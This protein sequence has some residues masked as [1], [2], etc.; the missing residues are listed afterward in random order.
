MVEIGNNKMVK[1][2]DQNLTETINFELSIQQILK[3]LHQSNKLKSLLHEMAIEEILI[4][5]AHSNGIEISNDDLQQTADDFRYRTGLNSALDTN[6]W[7][8]KHGLSVLDFEAFLERKLL[9]KKVKDL[10]AH[11]GA[12]DCFSSNPKNYTRVTYRIILVLREDLAQEIV[13]QVREGIGTFNELAF[14]YSQHPSREVGGLIQNQ[15]LKEMP[16]KIAELILCSRKGEII[17]P[18]STKIGFVLVLLE[19]VHP[20][21]LNSQTMVFI[22]EELIE[23]WLIEKIS[24]IDIKYPV[25]ELLNDQAS[26]LSA[27]AV[28]ITYHATT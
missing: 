16:V 23:K 1:F 17:G 20:P 22:K 14:K 21:E 12:V 3:N 7:L 28:R 15:I 18:I 4:N 11:E 27:P 13:T 26:S 6:N 25:L 2:H 5:H 19:E 24:R 10:L 9:I 8:G